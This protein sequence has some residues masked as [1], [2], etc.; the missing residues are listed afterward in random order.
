MIDPRWT[1]VA[2][3][4]SYTQILRN[5]FP[6]SNIAERDRRIDF[7]CV[8]EST[9][10]VVVEIKRPSV[11]VSKKDL[12]QIEDY[13]S[14]MRNYTKKTTDKYSKYEHVV[15]YLLCRGMVD[16]YQVRE[17]RDNLAEA[18]IYVKTYD[19]LLA[20]V[21]RSHREFM[22]RYNELKNAKQS[23]RTISS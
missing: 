20:A 9:N 7:L 13:V 21:Q 22:E 14:F 4:I 23:S 18:N 15:G 8:S 12:D 16:N 10:L 11:K 6:E 5:E 3:E 2:D 1:L 19:D 17:K